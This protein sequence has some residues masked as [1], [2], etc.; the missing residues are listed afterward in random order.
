MPPVVGRSLQHCNVNTL[1]VMTMAPLFSKHSHCLPQWSR[2]S[3]GATP[4]APRRRGR[5]LCSSANPA[6]VPVRS[7]TAGRRPAIL[8]CCPPP[9]WW[10]SRSS[11][12]RKALDGVALH[13]LFSPFLLQT[14]W[15]ARSPWRTPPT[16]RRGRTAASPATESAPRT[17]SCSSKSHLVRS[18]APLPALCCS[19]SW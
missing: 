19:T 5:T 3:R 18:S 16:V 7:S 4:T 8:N 12:I 9:L 11:L 1:S 2:P 10:V 15:A 14:P 6:R 13:H 17:A